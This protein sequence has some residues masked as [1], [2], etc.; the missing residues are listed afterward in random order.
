MYRATGGPSWNA[1][2]GANWLSDKPMGEWAGVTT[3]GG[4]VTQ[5]DLGSSG[6]SGE[7]PD[8]LGH[9]TRLQSAN[10][11]GN[12]LTGC[13]PAGT[14]LRNALTRSYDAG[15]GPGTEP[16]WDLII[17][18]ALHNVLV[19]EYGLEA[20]VSSDETLGWQDFLDRTNGL[21]LAP[22]PP[23]QVTAG[24]TPYA[25]QY[26]RTDREALLAIR[27][28]LVGNGTP[29]SS[30]QSW[31][32]EMQ[33]DRGI[34]PLRSGWRG[35]TLDGDGRVVKLWLDERGLKGDI[36]PQ[37]GSLGALRELNLSKNELTGAIPP[38]LGSLPNLRLLALNQN[39]TPKSS[40]AASATDGLSG[41]LPP[42]LGNLG[43]LRRLALDD[44]PFLVGE[45]PLELGNLTNLEHIHLQDTGFSGCLPPPIR[46]QFAPTPFSLV[47]KV[48]HAFTIE[49]IKPLMVEEVSNLVKA[50]GFARD[51]DEIL[52]YQEESIILFLVYAP[53][54]DA[55][56]EVSRLI[57]VLSPD[58]LIKPGS[59]L[60]NLGNVRLTC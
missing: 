58:T 27:D 47:N 30:F 11:R 53:L 14:R 59:T 22:C 39:F 16:G 52:E 44:N 49:R 38:E 43:E 35:V 3:E 40:G 8:R 32:G 48:L 54:N 18:H 21:G 9:L 60:S 1:D 19:G 20:V 17:L 4:Y 34:G 33:S 5:V 36:P 57:T 2:S 55:L 45:L 7:F 42:H 51:L 12:E 24:L 56:D 31:Q 46:Q 50:R 26:E 23:P 41:R 28:H 25:R 6:L 13:I 15:R 29:A 37:L 10:L